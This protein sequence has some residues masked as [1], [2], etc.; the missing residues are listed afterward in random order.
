M[1][2]P[3]SVLLAK[4]LLD[5]LR[6]R[7]PNFVQLPSNSCPMH[8]LSTRGPGIVHNLSNS[9]T[10][11]RDWTFQGLSNKVTSIAFQSGKTLD[12]DRL[13]TNFGCGQTLDTSWIF[14][15]AHKSK[16][17]LSSPK[18]EP[19]PHLMRTKS[20]ES[21][22]IDKL[23][24]AAWFFSSKHTNPTFVQPFVC[25]WKWTSITSQF[26]APYPWLVGQLQD[27]NTC[28]ATKPQVQIWGLNDSS[29]SNRRDN[30]E[31]LFYD[32]AIPSTDTWTKQDARGQGPPLVRFVHHAVNVSKA[33]LLSNGGIGIVDLIR[34]NIG[35]H[36]LSLKNCL[37]F[38]WVNQEHGHGCSPGGPWVHL[39]ITIF[40]PIV[41]L[42]SQLRTWTWAFSGQAVG[43]PWDVWVH[44]NLTS[45]CLF[46][47]VCDFW[48]VNHGHGRTVGRGRTWT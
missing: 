43:R 8:Y 16:Q 4:G 44:V 26:G 42:V 35:I 36:I 23:W 29:C 31:N 48:Q 46:F 15:H 19:V 37:F 14:V 2:I 13:W 10:L 25:F 9:Q 32:S 5:R 7:N 47:C 39:N 33:A 21:L 28:F 41:F 20:G 38:W 1:Y 34:G 30:R 22:D 12:R 11:D 18:N 45:F 40:V 17:P 3:W 27:K 24:T 6:T